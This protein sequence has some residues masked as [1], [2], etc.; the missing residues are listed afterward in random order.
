MIYYYVSYTV[1]ESTFYY[2]GTTF[3]KKSVWTRN[4]EDIYF[5]KV[6][7][8]YTSLTDIIENCELEHELPS[9]DLNNMMIHKVKLTIDEL[10]QTPILEVFKEYRYEE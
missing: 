6:E 3:L 5:F 9:I 2:K 7:P 4:K 1:G 8:Q 10:E